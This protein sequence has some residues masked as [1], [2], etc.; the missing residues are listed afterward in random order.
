MKKRLSGLLALAVAFVFVVPLCAV[1]VSAADTPAYTIHN[2]YA[3]V[4]WDSW[5][6]YKANLHTQTYFSDGAVSLA[7]T[8]EEYYRQGY[9]I[10]AITDHG[11]IGKRWDE[12]PQT[13]FPLDIQSWGKE[14][15]ILTTERFNEVQAGTDR[16][17]R[18]LLCVTSGIELNCANLTQTHVNGFFAGWGQGWWGFENDYRVAVHNTEKYGGISFL[19]H[20]W[21]WPL[22]ATFVTDPDLESRCR[23]WFF[24]D[25]L[26]AYPSCVGIEIHGDTALW[27]SLLMRLLPEGREVWGFTNDDMHKF[28][29][30]GRNAGFYPMETNT[31]TNL[32]TA[33]EN[34]VF[35]ASK[36]LTQ[37]GNA[38]LVTRVTVDESTDTLTL[39]TQNTNEVTWIADGAVIASGNSLSLRDYANQ[40]NCYVRAELRNAAGGVTYTQPFSLTDGKD[41]TVNDRP[42]AWEELLWNFV[43][44]LKSNFLAALIEKLSVWDGKF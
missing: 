5:A 39:T 19:N 34:G 42:G 22:T 24:A 41:H 12:A 27:D 14:R 31:V 35:F 32:R 3:A 38:P 30:I 6:L 2:P 43:R 8:V 36:G 13:N 15:T 10:L 21:Q 26:R 25:I 28:N 20:T 9:D 1:P 11:V 4:D 7:D 16:G 18:G 23:T 33:M 44:L 29:Q 40:I 17:G 37:G